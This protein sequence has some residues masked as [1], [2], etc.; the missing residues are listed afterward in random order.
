M[1][2]G[3]RSAPWL[4]AA[5]ALAFLV[6]GYG[7]GVLGGHLWRIMILAGG[8]TA[9]LIGTRVN[10]MPWLFGLAI[11]VGGLRVLFFGSDPVSPSDSRIV[12]EGIAS[13]AVGIA[14]IIVL[15]L[16]LRSR[17]GDLD[18][19]D[20]ID[21]LTVAIGASLST[22]IIVTSR[23][24][25]VDG[26]RPV[27]AISDSAY[28]PLSALLLTFILDLALSG[29]RSN[30]TMQFIALAAGTNL[31]GAVMLSF[32]SARWTSANDAVI[33]MFGAAFLFLC[34]GLSHTDAPAILRPERSAQGSVAYT[35]FRLA[36]T[37]ACLVVPGILV[38]ALAPFS[39]ID[40]AVRGGAMFLLVCAVLARLFIAVHRHEEATRA[41]TDRL[42][43]D[44]LTRL[45]TRVA[46]V[47]RVE[48]ILDDTWRSEFQ[49]TI[50]QLNLDRF[51]NINDSLGHEEANEVLVAVGGRL[52]TAATTFGGTVGRAGGDDFV[53]IDATTRSGTEAMERL[54][55]IRSALRDPLRIG[56]S[57][58]FVT[59]S[60]GVVTAPRNRTL[61]AEEMMRRAD[62]ATHRA[63]AA[64][65]NSVAVFDDSMQ[66]HLA[67]RMDVEN[68]LHG[69][70]G[71]GEMQL[72]HQPIVDITNGAVIGFEALI[73][74]QRDGSIVSPG[75]F[76]PI[77]EETGIINELGAW[78]LREALHELRGWI[79]DGVVAPN[80]TMSV[81]V[82]P[83]Q[84]A[85]PGFA[86]IV[87]RALEEARV[88]AELLWLE[89]TESMMLEEPDLAQHTLRE[90]RESGVRLALDDFGTGYSSLSLLQQFPIQRIKIDR[91]F[92]NGIATHGNDRSLV[93]TVIAMARSM[94]LDVV[95]EGVETVQQL[96]ALSDLSCDK[97][98]GYLISHPVPADAMRTTM[99][100]L[101][102]FASLSIFGATDTA[103]ASSSHVGEPQPQNVPVGARGTR[104]RPLGQPVP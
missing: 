13:S 65:R 66:S 59:A 47:Q 42:H 56:E 16:V 49:P 99:V 92:V 104:S 1:N 98:Q 64:G 36:L 52:A 83:R 95:A 75:D 90:I 53:V 21:V 15:S 31:V 5:G 26:W 80:T 19:R 17:R 51:K 8:L 25:F 71:R 93:R 70:I 69:A 81:N 37:G 4:L 101:D 55:T 89:M 73:R 39:P 3:I 35:P 84:I 96:H 54:E 58:V 60:F 103:V 18:E 11:C 33:G 9:F 100:A 12:T 76:I 50:I 20:G 102:E 6:A 68:S 82:S 41:L 23:T 94:S 91:A 14:L 29:L 48:Q 62:M 77:A 38:A 74:W 78:A 61:S 40:S 43:R 86:D 32:D 87:R 27:V 7:F 44:D 24:I 22:W 72:Y 88:P 79:D 10:R 97:A 34:A 63:K 57:N 85:D 30:R 45:P 2:R 28:L 67:R 46:F